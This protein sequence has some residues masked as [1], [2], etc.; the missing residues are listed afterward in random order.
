MENPFKIRLISTLPLVVGLALFAASGPARAQ[1]KP[2]ANARA[3]AQA[4]ARRAQRAAALRAAQNRNAQAKTAQS[5]AV[6]ETKSPETE[7]A[8]E[9]AKGTAVTGREPRTAEPPSRAE[10]PQSSEQETSPDGSRPM[11]RRQE[12]RQALR[13]AV[14]AGA[15]LRP[16]QRAGQAGPGAGGGLNAQR[17][18]QQ[19]LR[20]IGVT[21]EQLTRMDAVRQSHDDELV[22]MGRRIRQSR[23][24]L[25]QAIMS[26]HFDQ[27]EVDRAAEDLGNAQKAQVLLNAKIRAEQRQILTPEQVTRMKALEQQIQ[28]DRQ[29][30][31]RLELQMQEPD[32]PTRPPDNA[33][34]EK[35]N[36]PDP[37]DLI[38][39][40]RL[41]G[42]GDLWDLNIGD[43][44]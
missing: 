26:D 1:R 25:N 16:G 6:S 29:Q 34:I 12:A 15:G 32:S 8:D 43:I 27:A 11:R 21:P 33:P 10:V 2:Q 7:K 41:A 9:P 20:Q 35:D 38:F 44:F 5:K 30:Q 23:R 4:R 31:Q 3:A 37:L 19:V 17:L 36:D 40:P 39:Q 24:A 22:A 42:V 28:R 18:R 14:G 13:N